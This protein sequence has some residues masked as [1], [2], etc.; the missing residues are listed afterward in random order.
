VGVLAATA[1]FVGRNEENLGLSAAR[2][3]KIVLIA[4]WR[5]KVE[6]RGQTSAR[7]AQ[8]EILGSKHDVAEAGRAARVL[9]RQNRIGVAIFERVG[10]GGGGGH[11]AD[12]ARP[13]RGIHIY[14]DERDG[15]TDVPTAGDA[16]V[17]E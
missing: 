11:Q 4:R 10:V 9:H 3:E 5:A 6:R 1:A 17:R 2:T 13:H 15:K 14:A 16:V 8:N 12:D 7:S